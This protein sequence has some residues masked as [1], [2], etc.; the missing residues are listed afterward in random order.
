[1]L[2]GNDT[3]H[4]LYTSVVWHIAGPVAAHS[5]LQRMLLPRLL[6][7]TVCGITGITEVIVH[8]EADGTWYVSTEGSN[9]AALFE[10]PQ[11]SY[12]KRLRVL[13]SRCQTTNIPEIQ[14]G[15]DWA[16]THPRPRATSLGLEAV[17]WMFSDRASF[18]RR[19]HVLKVG[20]A[21]KRS[22]VVTVRSPGVSGSTM[23][24]VGR[25]SSCAG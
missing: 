16:S 12:H 7:G 8:R 3:L 24:P 17:C 6:D 11:R 2:V 15:R 18:Y 20:R 22:R 10:P 13:R 1:M 9:F 14:T 5:Y 21:L 4:W 23:R 19:V 25:T